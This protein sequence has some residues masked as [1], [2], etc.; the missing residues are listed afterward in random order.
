SA[1]ECATLLAACDCYRQHAPGGVAPDSLAQ[2]EGRLRAAL[3]FE[4]RIVLDLPRTVDMAVPESIPVPP[5]IPLQTAAME[6]ACTELHPNDL[7]AGGIDPPVPPSTRP[8][9]LHTAWLTL[10]L[11]LG[12]LVMTLWRRV[13]MVGRLTTPAAPQPAA[14]EPVSDPRPLIPDPRS[15]LPALH[16]AIERRQLLEI[17]YQAAA[18]PPTTR[19]IRPLRL[20]GHGDCWYLHAFCTLRRDER[21]FRVD[22][23]TALRMVR[24]VRRRGRP[25]RQERP[26]PARPP[27]PRPR[28]AP[29]RA[30]FFAPPPIP[31]PG[32][33]LVR[34]WLAD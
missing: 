3:P 8:T 24:L 12:L 32:S 30:S 27:R 15:H 13:S 18:G 21:L 20:E 16:Q 7:Q 5:V 34:V 22:R 33:P 19:I 14:D 4:Q 25:R 23:I 6:P 11:T 2:L 17:G 1:A 26:V 10:W 31:P 28:P 9:S 29:P